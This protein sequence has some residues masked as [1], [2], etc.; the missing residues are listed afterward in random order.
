MDRA[1][2]RLFDAVQSRAALAG[3][4]AG[5]LQ[6]HA[7]HEGGEVQSILCLGDGLCAVQLTHDTLA[8]LRREEA[9]GQGAGAVAQD[10]KWA[11]A[12]AVR[13]HGTAADAAQRVI[14]G[15]V[16][17]RCC[18]LPKQGLSGLGAGCSQ[19]EHEHLCDTS[20]ESAQEPKDL[21]AKPVA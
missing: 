1:L 4:E 15:A 3:R 19:Q 9:L 7:L 11:R 5:A 14:H 6:S 10:A 21:R 13:V 16:E 18:A 17:K 20:H 8:A 2:R 12:Q